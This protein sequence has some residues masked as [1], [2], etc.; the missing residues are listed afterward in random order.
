MVLLLIGVSH[1]YN[2]RNVLS[3][4]TASAELRRPAYETPARALSLI[5]HWLHSQANATA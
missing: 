1:Y 4:W 5:H 2:G 3:G